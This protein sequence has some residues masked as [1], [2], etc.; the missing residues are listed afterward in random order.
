MEQCGFWKNC[1]PEC[2]FGLASAHRRSST[3]AKLSFPILELELT[4]GESFQVMDLTS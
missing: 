3:D 4:D 1:Y 2:H